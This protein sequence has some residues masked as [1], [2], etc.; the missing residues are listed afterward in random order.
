MK[1]DNEIKSQVVY[2][3]FSNRSL[4]EEAVQQL[5]THGFRQA[6]IS[7]LFSSP[8]TTKEFAHTKGTKA[9]E[10]AMYGGSIG[11]VLGGVLGALVGIG[12]IAIPGVGP[13]IAAGPIMAS[14][15]GIGAG[16]ITGGI[17]GALI[18]IGFPEYEAKRY[19][20]RIKEGG[21]LFSVNCDNTDW[22]QTA[23]KIL[24]DCGAEDIS[25]GSLATADF[26][27]EHRPH[28]YNL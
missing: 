23:A 25:S 3:L 4:V 9:P 1:N 5:T 2:G 27:D 18:G 16:G 14:L 6:D 20:G 19:E 15:A 22:R 8:E 21:I 11:A 24:E 10:G 26:K 17:T 28:V 13:F 7:V 12:S